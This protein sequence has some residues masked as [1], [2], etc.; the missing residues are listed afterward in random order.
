MYNF[1][2]VSINKYIIYTESMNFHI[3]SD[4][5]GMRLSQQFYIDYFHLGYDVMYYVVTSVV[6]KSAASILSVL[7]D[8]FQKLKHV[9]AVK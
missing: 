8:I 9:I 3:L 1:A 5:R 7:S 6:Q 4:M 2:Y